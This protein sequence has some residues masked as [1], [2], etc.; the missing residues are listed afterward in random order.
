[1]SFHGVPERVVKKG[2]PYLDHCTETAKQ[3]AARLELADD[4]WQMVF[5]SRFGA[6]AWLKP[7]CVEVLENLPKQ[8]I[9]DID[10]ICPGFAVDCLETLEEI[11]IQNREI[12][13]Q[14]GGERY[15]YIPALNDAPD[16]VEMLMEII[17]TRLQSWFGRPSAQAPAW[18]E[19]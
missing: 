5:Q 1:M 3:L 9:T 10:V 12:F 8:G 19:N 2:D 14:A 4:A 17:E 18:R 11:S 13:I 16:H 6:E 15:Q 7:Y